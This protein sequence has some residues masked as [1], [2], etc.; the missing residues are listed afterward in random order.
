MDIFSCWETVETDPGSSLSLEIGLHKVTPP[1]RE[2][3]GVDFPS[4]SPKEIDLQYVV[5]ENIF[6]ILLPL[7]QFA[8]E[9][10]HH[11]QT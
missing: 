6:D 5:H 10:W 8:C 1:L 9:T 2:E 3:D 4:H 7:Q 11:F